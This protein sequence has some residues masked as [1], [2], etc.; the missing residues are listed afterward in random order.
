MPSEIDDNSSA[1][2]TEVTQAVRTCTRLERSYWEGIQSQY[3]LRADYED[4]KP[5]LDDCRDLVRLLSGVVARLYRDDRGGMKSIVNG[6]LGE[7]WDS[8]SDLVDASR[9]TERETRPTERFES[10]LAEVR[11][12]VDILATMTGVPTDLPPRD[13]PVSTQKTNSATTD[14]TRVFIVHGHDESTKAEVA[15]LVSQLGLKPIVLNE[16]VSRSDTVIEKLEAYSDVGF[17]V[18]LLTPD[19]L[20]AAAS[21]RNNL[22]P[23]ARQ[24]VVLELG[25]FLGKCG[26]ARVCTLY[27]ADVE[28]PSDW[29]GVVYIP[30]D[31]QRAWRLTLAKELQAFNPDVDLNAL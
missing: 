24:N 31:K 27:G 2:K 11:G 20:G 23:R 18:V 6:H 25:Y 8:F 28:L 29:R 30:L 3:Y 12:D 9:S 15:L 1:N 14:T 22:R 17:A 26:R 16:Q 13:Q 10:A 21:D 4:M 7:L 19:D 5:V